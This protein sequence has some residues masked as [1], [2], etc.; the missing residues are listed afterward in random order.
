MTK[1]ATKQEQ[2]ILCV[3]SVLCESTRCDNMM[4][5]SSAGLTIG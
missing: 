4:N 5:W 1:R 3:V 2:D